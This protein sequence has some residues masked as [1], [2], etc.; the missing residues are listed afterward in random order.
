MPRQI[1]APFYASKDV[2]AHN[3][4]NKEEEKQYAANVAQGWQG[5]NK[6][7]QQ[8]PEALGFGDEPEDAYNPQ[9]SEQG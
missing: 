9:H 3:G 4:I 5:E 7:L 1:L 2:H 8:S 6:G